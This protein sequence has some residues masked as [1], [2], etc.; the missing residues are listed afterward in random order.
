MRLR[1]LSSRC[2][3]PSG[4]GNAGIKIYEEGVYHEPTEEQRASIYYSCP[5]PTNDDNLYSELVKQSSKSLQDHVYDDHISTTSSTVSSSGSGAP[6]F[7]H[8]EPTYWTP[9]DSTQ[10]LYKQLSTRKYRELSRKHVSLRQHLGSGQFGTV[11]Q[12]VWS[13]PR[14]PVDVAVKTLK[15]G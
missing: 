9:A 3:E 4:R 12:G 10:A 1:S 13:S 6:A 15:P 5:T 2:G 7:F 14:G 8:E 11:V